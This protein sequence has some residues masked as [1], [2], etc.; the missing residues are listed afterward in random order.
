LISSYELDR[1]L[2]GATK[3]GLHLHSQTP[4]AISAEYSKSRRHA[5]KVELRTGEG[6]LTSGRI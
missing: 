1:Y 5:K 4:H 6:T 2:A 3:E